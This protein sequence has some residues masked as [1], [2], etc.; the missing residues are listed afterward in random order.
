MS[1]EQLTIDFESLSKD[2][3]IREQWDRNIASQSHQWSVESKAMIWVK[4]HP[5]VWS[6]LPTYERNA[7][8][9][10]YLAQ[11]GLGIIPLPPY[12]SYFSEEQFQQK[13]QI[14][15]R[16]ADQLSAD[17]SSNRPPSVFTCDPIIAGAISL[18]LGRRVEAIKIDP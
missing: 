6:Q 16:M 13:M 2:R 8:V 5:E 14:S 7:I 1:P 10:D 18:I 17:W 9:A 11:V 4:C 12:R 3:L 15:K